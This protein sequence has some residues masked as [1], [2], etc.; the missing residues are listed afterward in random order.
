MAF[1]FKKSTQNNQ[2]G[3]LLGRSEREDEA[4]VS[5]YIESLS[6]ARTTQDACFIVLLHYAV[7]QQ[8]MQM[9][10][11]CDF[12]I[13]FGHDQGRN[14]KPFHHFNGFGSEIIRRNGFGIPRGQLTGRDLRKIPS[15]LD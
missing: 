7:L 3:V 8:V 15:L 12:A 14:G 2:T 9:D 6:D 13:P 1:F 11:A 4:Y 10:D 5:W